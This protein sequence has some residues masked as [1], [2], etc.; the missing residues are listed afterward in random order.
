MALKQLVSRT[1]TAANLSSGTV[2]VSSSKK[3]LIFPI[4][5]DFN[6]KHYLI[7]SY[8]I[9]FRNG[10]GTK[11][12]IKL[13][14][15]DIESLKV[16]AAFIYSPEYTGIISNT[17]G[18][19]TQNSPYKSGMIT[20][21]N[22]ID[23]PISSVNAYANFGNLAKPTIKSNIINSFVDFKKEFKIAFATNNIYN[24][25]EQFVINSGVFKFREKNTQDEYSQIDFDEETLIIQANTLNGGKIYECYASCTVDDGQIANSPNIELSTVD[26]V[27]V[28][29]P[30]YP[31]NM[32][33]YDSTYFSWEFSNKT[34]TEQ[35]AYD[36]EISS[37]GTIWKSIVNH[38][39][40]NKTVTEMLDV[41]VGNV[42]WRVR[43]YN[44]ND[45]PSEWSEISLFINNSPPPKPVLVGI[46]SKGRPLIKWTAENQIGYH[47]KIEDVYDS[48]EIYTS[49]K[50][51]LVNEY[52]VN[53]EYNI[54]LRII[55]DLGKSSNWLK[56]E[57][58]QSMT[59]SNPQVTITNTELGAFIYISKDQ[60]VKYYIYRNDVCIA[61]ITE[62]YLDKYVNGEDTYLIRGVD[63]FDN[64]SDTVIKNNFT[65]KKSQLIM[66]YGDMYDL[67]Y[68][69]DNKPIHN[70]NVNKDST[71]V[72]Y[73]GRKYVVHKQ[74]TIETKEFNVQC[75]TDFNRLGE[76]M[77]YRNVF[78][79]KGWVICNQM[80]IS[81]ND[82]M[83]DVTLTLE[84]TSYKEGIEYEI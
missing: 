36:L 63:Q 20:T 27:P 47:L 12:E 72:S 68:R 26:S 19:A 38:Q 50:F 78:G 14:K 83:N 84:Q 21:S 41:D 32:V 40:T 77:F 65:S 31:I 25:F 61:N 69:M 64:F 79:N 11:L 54:Q 43:G 22:Q 59:L 28:V 10:Q 9:T 8:A 67:S 18:T 55:N 70:F 15:E 30:I 3:E 80:A 4:S 82:L 44:Q 53:G 39:I 60:F 57:Y 45:I 75:N 16:G 42:Y 2:G 74:G 13:I 33:V 6:K 37:D 35:F 23:S 71:K 56:I 48:G 52:I 34:G 29:K 7:M 1:V 81:N 51:H 17:G 58:I 5:I 49:E 66:L 46:E 62:A 76:I 24:M 73:I